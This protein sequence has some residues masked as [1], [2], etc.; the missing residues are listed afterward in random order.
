MPLWFLSITT[1]FNAKQRCSIFV[2]G[3]NVVMLGA[4]V[5]QEQ[6][7]QSHFSKSFC[8][9]LD[10]TNPP[11]NHHQHY[12]FK[13]FLPTGIASSCTQHNL[14]RA[15]ISLPLA[16]CGYLSQNSHY[17]CRPPQ[18]LLLANQT[19]NGQSAYRKLRCQNCI[20]RWAIR[21]TADTEVTSSV[22]DKYNLSN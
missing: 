13:S 15:I 3:N 16:A 20:K 19:V 5:L 6:N 2:S 10:K 12:E 18:N 14:F 22:Q 4:S 11:S 8:W 9:A 7:R 1:V 21:C 17:H